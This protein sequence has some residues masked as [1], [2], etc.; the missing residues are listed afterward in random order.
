MNILLLLSCFN[1]LCLICESIVDIRKLVEP[2]WFRSRQ[3]T[4]SHPLTQIPSVQYPP[5]PLVITPM[6]VSF[7]V[8][9]HFLISTTPFAYKSLN[10]SMKFSTIPKNFENA[11]NHV[12]SMS[13]KVFLQ[14]SPCLFPS[15]LWL[16]T[17]LSPLECS[18]V[19][20]VQTFY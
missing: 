18:R 14:L 13:I 5:D 10:G 11:C 1:H 6:T 19:S 17:S 16:Y 2:F 15:T 3:D 20:S 12:N 7:L 9:L 4:L 8:T